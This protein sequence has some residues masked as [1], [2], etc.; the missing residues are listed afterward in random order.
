MYYYTNVGGVDN[1]YVLVDENFVY[2]IDF[3]TAINI[4][5]GTPY[6][7]GYIEKV[8]PDGFT[9]YN[10]PSEDWYVK[11]K[12]IDRFDVLVDTMVQVNRSS[13]LLVTGNPNSVDYTYNSSTRSF[14]GTVTL[15]NGPFSPDVFASTLS[16][17]LTKT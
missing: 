7:E 6:S 14:D 8:S 3:Q 10:S 9:Y 2:L 12:M 5:N 13:L 4:G 1:Y 17:L 15:P 16:E 11:G